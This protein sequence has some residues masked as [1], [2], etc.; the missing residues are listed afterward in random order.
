MTDTVTS[1]KALYRRVYPHLPIALQNAALSTVGWHNDLTCRGRGFSRLLNEY[2]ARAFADPQEIREYR[3]KRLKAFLLYAYETVPFYRELF[4]GVGLHPQELV[5]LDD[6]AALPILS[7]AVVQ[8]R[9]PSF[10]STSISRRRWKLIST[11][12]TTGAGL[13]LATTIEAVQEQWAAWWRFWRWHGIEL[14]TWVALLGSPTAIPVSQDAPPFWRYNMP[15]HEIIFG[16]FHTSRENLKYY[17]A[18]LRRKKPPWLHG[19]ASQLT[20][21]ASYLI[22]TGTDLGYEARWITVS[23]ENLLPQQALLIEKAFGVRPRQHYGMV[24]AIANISECE[25]GKLHVD[26]ELSA[27]EFVPIN[28]SIYRVIGTN[29]SNPVT[30]LIRYDCHDHVTIEPGESCS[31][32]R[33]GRVITSIDGRREDYVVLKSGIRLGRL[34]RIFYDFPNVHEAQIRQEKVGEIRFLVRRGAHYA[35]EDDNRLR[36][37]IAKWIRDGSKISI[38]YVDEIERTA[39]GKLRYVVS[40]VAPE[41]AAGHEVLPPPAL[42]AL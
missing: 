14:G 7:K 13:T 42:S 11:S 37:E 41:E 40:S 35:N 38:E 5:G 27:V 10:V 6:L 28:D 21:I 20:L 17:I 24:E 16:S 15:G 9:Q 36:A 4:D 2:E 8:E 1:L 32:G 23:T 18:E 31:C 25:Y 34:D 19:L 22:E 29:F 33:P 30:P 3:D 26:E 12:G 39:M